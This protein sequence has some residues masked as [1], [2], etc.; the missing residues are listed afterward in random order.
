[1]A[2]SGGSDGGLSV[3]VTHAPSSFDRLRAATKRYELTLTTGPE[4]ERFSVFVEPPLFPDGGSPLYPIAPGIELVGPAQITGGVNIFSHVVC[5]PAFN[6]V[7]GAEP[8]RQGIDVIAPANSSSLLRLSFGVW[9]R[10]APF[11]GM[12]VRPKVTFSDRLENSEPGATG[13]IGADQVVLP[14]APR[15]IGPTGVRISFTT[16]PWTPLTNPKR[17]PTLRPG[18]TITVSGRTEPA[19]K[20]Q[21][22]SLRTVGPGQGRPK[23]RLLA[24]VRTDRRGRFRYEWSPRRPGIHQL[25]AFYR[26]QRRGVTSDRACPRYVRIAR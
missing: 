23:L 8:M 20:R 2:A 15:L 22:V 14:E 11:R 9:R 3:S 10:D 12:A 13:T 19:L 25:F 16:R 26:R 6:V 21:V 5:S 18:R 24:R 17:A 7:H 1:M 4:D